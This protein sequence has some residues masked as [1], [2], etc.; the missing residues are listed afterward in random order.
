MFQDFHLEPTQNLKLGQNKA[1]NG[2]GSLEIGGSAL[3]PLAVLWLVFSGGWLGIGWG[4]HATPAYPTN[5]QPPQPTAHHWPTGSVQPVSPISGVANLF[6][7][8]SIQQ[9]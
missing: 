9:K 6:P 8:L 7:A 5:G 2:V 1:Q 4:G 3:T